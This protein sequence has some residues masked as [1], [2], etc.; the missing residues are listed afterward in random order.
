MALS[1]IIVMILFKMLNQ[2]KLMHSFMLNI[3]TMFNFQ[4]LLDKAQ[5]LSNNENL[6][7]CFLPFLFHMEVL[8]L[9]M[10]LQY[11][12]TRSAMFS[13]RVRLGQVMVNNSA[14]PAT[15][16]CNMALVAWPSLPPPSPTT[17][18]RLWMW[19]K[20]AIWV[21][22]EEVKNNLHTKNI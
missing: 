14:L 18:C 21:G 1:Y 3:F 22:W 16:N 10:S 8:E 11:P 2:T 19:L 15:L 6:Y 5:M 9:L 17:V 12:S 13:A 20:S 4:L 7:N